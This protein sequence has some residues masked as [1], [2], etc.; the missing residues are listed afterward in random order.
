MPSAKTIITIAVV[1]V[2][3]IA[4]VFRIGKVRNIVTGQA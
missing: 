1:A 2:V 3:A 4:L